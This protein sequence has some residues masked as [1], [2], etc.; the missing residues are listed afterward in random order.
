MS[1]TFN[2]NELDRSLSELKS[3]K[4]DQAV[5]LKDELRQRKL[6]LEK[7]LKNRLNAVA[8]RKAT[9][10]QYLRETLRTSAEL[11]RSMKRE[12]TE[13]KRWQA[14]EQPPF[15]LDSSSSTLIEVP[16]ALVSRV[17][18]AK[19]YALCAL[20]LLLLTHIKIRVT[21]LAGVRVGQEGGAR[22]LRDHSLGPHRQ[23]RTCQ[24]RGRQESRPLRYALCAFVLLEFF[25]ICPIFVGSPIALAPIQGEQLFGSDLSLSLTEDGESDSESLA[26]REYFKHRG[27]QGHILEEDSLHLGSGTFATSSEVNGTVRS[28]SRPRQ[29]SNAATNDVPRLV[30]GGIAFSQAAG[31]VGSSLQD[32]AYDDNSSWIS[33]SS[34]R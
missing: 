14:R 7:S 34:G 32:A 1:S 13:A 29:S 9:E 26:I 28:P 33:D 12:D 3:S 19:R 31:S 21:Q 20:C 8:N 27:V 11:S 15:E 6:Q 24:G 16:P 17:K 18:T 25:L 23:L 4:S 22:L 2:R 10:A 30:G 5:A